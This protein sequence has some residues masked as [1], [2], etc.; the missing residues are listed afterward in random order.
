[1]FTGLHPDYHR[2]SDTSD[3]INYEGMVKIADMVED[4]VTDLAARDE[5]LTF[6]NVA[7]SMM[8]TMQE[9]EPRNR[10]G[11]SSKDK[12]KTEKAKDDKPTSASAR[13]RVRIGIMPDYNTD[14]EGVL[15]QGVS[16]DSPAAKAGLKEGDLIVEMGGQPVKSVTGYMEELTK[17]QPGKV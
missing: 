1:F 17:C 14:L 12:A 9:R 7:G 4:I 8:P 3:K 5:K 11:D 15:L 2:P 6:V 10:S 16:P 13:M